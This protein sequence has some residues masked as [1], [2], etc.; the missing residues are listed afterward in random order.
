V[1]RCGGGGAEVRRRAP[2]AALPGGRALTADGHRPVG[3]PAAVGA[4][5]ESA[6]VV[7]CHFRPPG[8]RAGRIG[9]PRRLPGMSPLA[10]VLIV[11]GA[12]ILIFLVGGL[13]H[14]RRRLNDPALEERIRAADQA[15]A[16]ARASDKGWDRALLD[17][18]TRRCLSEQRPELRVRDLYLVH[19]DDRPGVEEDRA[20]MLAVCGDDQARVVL[21]RN[22]AGDWV[23][24]HI[25]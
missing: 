9:R 2:T 17:E 22:P 19:V 3:S 25:E 24:D 6:P 16:H 1:R 10:I 21:T 18:A 7:G 14:S 20:H 8:G 11:L 13:I 23:L 4:S 12:L 15:L 5:G